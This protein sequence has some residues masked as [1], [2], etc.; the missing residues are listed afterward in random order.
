MQNVKEDTGMRHPVLDVPL[1][2]A[3]VGSK[4][5]EGSDTRRGLRTPGLLASQPVIGLLLVLIGGAMFGV[6]AAGIQP[7]GFLLNWDGL[8]NTDVHALALQSSPIVRDAMILGFYLGEHGIVAIG[9]LLAVYFV[10]KR[11]WPE[12][13]MVVIAWSGEGALWLAVSNAF[14]RPRPVFDIVIW[15]HMT[16]PGFPSGHAFSAVMCFG[17]LAY[18]CVPRM[19]SR[20]WKWAVIML[21]FLIMVYIGCSRIFVGDHYLTDV[22]AG[23]ALGVAWSGLVVTM[24]ELGAR[25]IATRSANRKIVR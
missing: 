2:G 18:L 22:L 11:F 19:P 9:L 5:S 10:Y 25:W 4:G 8:V 1:S 14:H 21:A 24:V 15:H 12:L 7:G 3:G 17:L 23:Y 13:C 16:A 6:I 20:A